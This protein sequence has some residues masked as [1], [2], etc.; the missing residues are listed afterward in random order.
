MI[1]K[2]YLAFLLLPGLFLSST[3][4]AQTITINE[5][6]FDPKGSEYY[7]EFI[8][9]V[10]IG[11][12]AVSL[13]G[14]YLEINGSID[15]LYFQNSDTLAPNSYALILDRGY[16]IDEKSHIYDELIPDNALLLTIQGQTFGS[17]GLLNSSPDTLYLISYSGDTLS[18]VYTT[19]D[20]PEGYSDEKILTD[21]P[22]SPDNWGNSTEI[23]GTP[24]FKNSIFPPDYDLAIITIG[25]L[26]SNIVLE[27]GATVE[28]YLTIRNVGLNKINDAELVFGVDSDGDSILRAE[29]VL[30]TYI[31]SIEPGDSVVKHPT[32]QSVLAGKTTVIGSILSEDDNNENNK[33]LFDLKVPY[34]TGSVIIN[35]IMYQ[36]A[37]GKS[38][39]FE[40]FN[41][42]D[43]LVNLKEWSFKRS[44]TTIYVMTDSAVFIEPNS[45]AVI[46]ES[47]NHGFDIP[48][49][50]PIVIPKK[51]PSLTNTADSVVIFDAVEHRID[52]LR[53]SSEGGTRT[54]VS[55]ERIDP[56]QE[57]DMSGNWALSQNTNGGTPGYNNSVIIKDFDL[58]ISDVGML[59]DTHY[60]K[61]GG[62][63][64]LYINIKNIGR[65]TIDNA[66]FYLGIDSNRDS[67]LQENEV[68]YV[69]VL[70]ISSGDSV[71]LYPSVLM[72][73]SGRNRII[74]SIVTDDDDNDNNLKFFILN[75]Q[76]PTGCMVINEFMYVP[77]TDFGGEW[78]ELLNVSAD[79]INLANWRIGDNA[80]KIVISEKI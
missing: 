69:D 44:T 17:S 78:I 6:M 55:L 25:L 50:I 57:G 74:C 80:S 14:S 18:T 19:P 64:D 41:R 7:D 10:N 70:T 31:L 60:P 54:G 48:A 76:Y 9:I 29:E 47:E 16:L 77:K 24:G 37:S 32:L 20:Q 27:P 71:V 30:Q 72:A 11:D 75:V 36:P 3:A 63:A 8:E 40:L 42:S 13:E 5:V 12:S 15:S 34:P 58:E 22:N 2:V 4:I 51:F 73:Y 59:D 46:T 26:D 23:Y 35:E 61:P 45:F 52:A 66:E 62:T 39:W 28:L 43:L 67:V 33:F 56:Y 21:G 49:G 68:L 79:T 53:Y 65:E 1:K 38:E